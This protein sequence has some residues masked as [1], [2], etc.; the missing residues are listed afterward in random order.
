MKS[1]FRFTIFTLI[2][3]GLNI[4]YQ[5]CLQVQACLNED[6]T[7]CLETY[8]ITKEGAQMQ[9]EF[10]RRALDKLGATSP[11]QVANIWINGERL[12]NGVF[13]YAVA[14]DELKSKMIKQW[15]EPQDSVWIIGGS[16][17]WLENDEIVYINKLNAFEYEAK[18]KFFWIS[19]GLSSTTETILLIV[20]NKDI[21]CVKEVE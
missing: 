17:P 1:I 9:V 12:R 14:C 21:W 11:E 19:G 8:P 5:E 10:F 4:K 18:I 13:H 20:K 7:Q 6:N 2:I 15:G 16:S 3:L